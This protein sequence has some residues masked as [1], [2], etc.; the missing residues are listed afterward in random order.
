MILVVT[1]IILSVNTRINHYNDLKEQTRKNIFTVKQNEIKNETET[2]IRYI[3]YEKKNYYQNVIDRLKRD[4]KGE[5]SAIKQIHKTSSGKQQAFKK[6]EAF[7]NEMESD[8]NFFINTLNGK[9]LINFSR[10]QD[11]GKMLTK[12]TDY[13]G[14]TVV[15]NEIA[16]LQSDNEKLLEY[17][18][19]NDSADLF[20]NKVTFIQKFEPLGIY[21]GETI[22][23]EDYK[24]NFK[25]HLLHLLAEVRYGEEGYI[26]VNTYDGEALIKDGERVIPPVNLWQLTDPNGIKV[27][28]EEY[29]AVQKPNGDFIYYSWRKLNSEEVVPKMSFVKGVEE[30][31]WMIGTGTYL[32]AIDKQLALSED[33]LQ[34][35]LYKEIMLLAGLFII[36]VVVAF[37]LL[38]SYLKSSQKEIAV[39]TD[40]LNRKSEDEHFLNTAHIRYSEFKTMGKIL[41]TLIEKHHNLRQQITKDRLLLRY[42]I[43]SIPDAISYKD[44][45]RN[46]I[47][48][49][50]AFETAYGIS[51]ERM[52]NKNARQIFDAETAMAIENMEKQLYAK[53]KPVKQKIWISDVNG[54]KIRIELLKAFYYDQDEN[55]LGI[56]TIGRLNG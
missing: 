20:N 8:R 26:F 39:F 56:I 36:A 44:T 18:L 25:E 53:K 40:Y 23:F 38:R 9:S 17:S 34:Q 41:N 19:S 4:V 10:P 11:E 15:E 21:A 32:D 52:K 43:D 13:L 54:N 29:N 27:I 14:N 12:K 42:L 55:I 7:Y 45:M 3:H 2:A 37:F 6:V 5:I 46:Y 48:C 22:Y 31:K 33:E 28:Q 49:N 24:E 51:E 30:L 35:N 1:L 50:K 16:A 47:G